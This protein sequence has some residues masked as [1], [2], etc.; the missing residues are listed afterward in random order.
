MIF[1]QPVAC[2]LGPMRFPGTPPVFYSSTRNRLMPTKPT[3][4][5]SPTPD[6]NDPT[7]QHA[8]IDIDPPYPANPPRAIRNF[9]K[10]LAELIARRLLANRDGSADTPGI[11]ND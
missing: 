3:P 6:D 9:Q 7:K 4:S 1:S 8:R 11:N 5:E 2:R 10:L